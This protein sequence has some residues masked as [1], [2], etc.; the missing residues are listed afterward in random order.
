MGFSKLYFKHLIYKET[1][2][3]YILERNPLKG[4]SRE[5]GYNRRQRNSLTVHIFE[6]RIITL[7]ILGSQLLDF[8]ATKVSKR[9]LL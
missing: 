4:A 2:E 3:K 1:F 6:E 8:K 9:A 7:H 5:G